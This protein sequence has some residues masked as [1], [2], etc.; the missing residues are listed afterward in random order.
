MPE[1]ARPPIRIVRD[2]CGE[3]VRD[4][5]RRLL[6]LGYTVPPDEQVAQF[7]PATEQ[8]VR[9]FQAKRGLR[10]DGVVGPQTWR[11]LDESRH[12]L[13]DRLLFLRSPMLRGDDVGSLQRQ[14]N[15]LGFDAGREDAIFGP[16]TGTALKELQRNVGLA[17]DGICGPDTIA[18]LRRFGPP[19]E[20]SVS[21]IREQ[22]QL[23]R[24][25]FALRDRT[26]ALVI[27]PGL[28]VVA[29]GVA[30]ALHQHGA[31]VWSDTCSDDHSATA[32]RA[33]RAGVDVCVALRLAAADGVS[34]CAYFES[35]PFRSE[36]GYRMA[37]AVCDELG[38]ALVPRRFLVVGSRAAL[39]RET[40][41]PAI[42][43]EPA[44]LGDAG[45]LHDLVR[46]PHI[47]GDAIGEGVRRGLE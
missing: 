5:Q 28:E 37:R 15:A 39:V 3:A 11:A 22:E 35:G 1:A 24:S 25:P 47:V 17:A 8:A 16:Q 43:C 6:A 20:Q 45:A 2:D 12:R 9:D 40:R 29:T 13:G 42:V 30:R 18:S 7:G 10:V 33:N 32:Q 26:V 38:D 34:G 41:M 23:R 46:R 36:S 31:S 27:E 4:L 19:R 21:L 14:L 44:R